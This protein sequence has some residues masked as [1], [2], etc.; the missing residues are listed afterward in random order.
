MKN[1]I[2]KRCAMLVVALA[3]YASAGAQDV[4]EAYDTTSNDFCA[5]V[6]GAFEWEPVK[7]L[8]LEAELQLRLKDDLSSVDR[9][10][11]TF[12]LNYEVCD[13]VA[14][15]AD[16]VL[17]NNHDSVDKMWEKPRH[18]LNV[19]V[20]GSVRLGRVELSLRERVQTTFRTDSVNRFEK[21]DPEMILRSKLQ[22]EY[23]IRH[24]RWTPY[25]MFELHNTLN[26]PAV[27]AN[28]KTAE[29]TRD[30]YITRYRAGVGAKYRLS[31]NHRLEFYYIFDY[32]RSYDIDYKGNKGDLKGYVR[33]NE[34]RHIFG[35]SYK[36]KL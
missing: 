2:I 10:Q 27:V 31:R 25:V 13:Y 19:N 1:S 7:N 21:P 26:A 14:I 33:E 32:D 35:I 18:R 22:A 28:Y 24:S 36:F 34:F 29:L 5:R 3:C 11:T 8:S 4:A 23:S 6:D 15:G 9:F 17:I 30:N 20:E 12:G 16:Y